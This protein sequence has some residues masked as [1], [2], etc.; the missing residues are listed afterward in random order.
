MDDIPLAVLDRNGSQESR[1]LVQALVSSGYFTMEARIA[2]ETEATDRLARGDVRGALV[3]PPA[4]ARELASGRRAPVQLLLDGSDA[5]TATIALNYADAIVS[6]HSARVLL[7]GRT[8]APPLRVESRVWYNPELASRMMIVPALIAVLMSIIAALLTALT[9][10]REW[11]RGTMEQLAATPV[12]RLEVVLGKLLPYLGIGLFDV[13]LTVA[14]GMIIFDT[15]L[16]G[17]PVLLALLTFLFLVVDLP[18]FRGRVSDEV[19]KLSLSPGRGK[20]PPRSGGVEHSD[21]RDRRLYVRI[22]NRLT[23][24]RPATPLS[25]RLDARS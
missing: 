7:Q 14:A 25:E 1:S 18:R 4:L 15:P 5:N 10:A 13:A 16:R 19:F 22:R 21:A 9:I 11:E 6:R 17:G 8:L 20:L 3:I 2:S 12:G 23:R 24:I